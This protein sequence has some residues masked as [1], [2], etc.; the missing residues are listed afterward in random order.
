MSQNINFKAEADLIWNTAD[1]ILRDVFTRTEY[2]DIIY[3]MVL[4]R[5]IEC[6]LEDARDQVREQYGDKLK[7]LPKSAFTKLVEQACGFNNKSKWTLKKLTGESETALKD[8]FIAYLNGYTKNITRIIGASGIR[9]DINKLYAKELLYPLLKRYAEIDLSPKIASNIKMGYIFEELV[10]RFS[11][12]NNAEAGE[13]YTPREVIQLMVQLLDLDE[14]GI[15]DGELARIFD[16]AC[17][18]GGMLSTAKEYIEQRINPKAN[19]RLF[20]QEV[21][22]KTWAICEADMI[23]KGEQAV[24][25]QDDTLTDDGFP[26]DRF[27]YMISNPPYGKSWK[28]IKAKVEKNNNGRFDAGNPRSSDGQ[29]L[30]LQHMISKMKPREMGGSAIAIVLNGSPLFTGD[31]GSGE[32]EIRRWIVENDWL[33]TII[34]LP[35]D[36]FYNTG[37]A[38]YI[39]IVRNN[40]KPKRKGKVQLING[41]SFFN[42]MTKSLGKKRNYISDAQIAQLIKIHKAFK[43]S[44]HSKSFS[45]DDFAYRKVFLDLEELDEDGNPVYVIKV[46][47]LTANRFK[48]IVSVRTTAEKRR[49]ETLLDKT[50]RNETDF[51]FKL[52][53]DSE[54]IRQHKT[55]QTHIDIG[56]SLNGAR[57]AYSAEIEVPVIV[58]DTENIPWKTEVEEFLKANVEKPWTITEIK[59][60]YEI[61]F[62][63][64]FYQYQPLRSAEEVLAEFARLERDNAALLA[65]LNMDISR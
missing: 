3:P 41:V 14:A 56:K 20:G 13:H 52:I 60:G 47:N 39:W 34:A 15:R 18:T 7:K 48:K 59:K 58:K 2:P 55:P 26:G 25:V 27:D 5:R 51:R 42:K 6:V 33:E 62:T 23:L 43:E 35:T 17:G 46:V 8:N 1:D 4:I 22:D 21:N 63:Q 24:I 64:Y 37:I 61:P 10:R 32:S 31:A 57:L 50:D 28:T 30:F 45:N 65:E 16:P 49:L 12:Q 53:P 38:T 11:E 29:L 54:F 40:K 36:L 44:E 19:V 9:G